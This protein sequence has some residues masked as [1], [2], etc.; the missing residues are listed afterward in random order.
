MYVVT[1]IVESCLHLPIHCSL[2]TSVYA[3]STCVFASALHCVLAST[4]TTR[5]VTVR[6]LRSLREIGNFMFLTDES[7]S[8]N[9]S[10]LHLIEAHNAQQ[11]LLH[12]VFMLFK[13]YNN[14]PN[15]FFF[16]IHVVHF[17]MSSGIMSLYVTHILFRYKLEFSVQKM[18]F[19][20]N[21]YKIQLI[22]S[23]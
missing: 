18:Y 6:F 13:H 23:S 20:F 12:C 11:E 15:M 7:S 10:F 8:S 5:V 2:H 14:G 3:R 22:L 17:H 9:W 4:V 16:L 21:C 1:V 19:I